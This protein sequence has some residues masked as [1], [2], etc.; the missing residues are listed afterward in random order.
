MGLDIGLV[1]EVRSVGACRSSGNENDD[2]VCQRFIYNTA[3]DAS[4]WPKVGRATLPVR[5]LSMQGRSPTAGFTS[6]V[7]AILLRPPR[8]WAID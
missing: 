8:Q 3:Y 7:M 5:A 6:M 1:H 4:W 2:M